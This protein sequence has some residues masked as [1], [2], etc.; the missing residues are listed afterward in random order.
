[1]KVTWQVGTLA[2]LEKVLE[3]DCSTDRFSSSDLFIDCP[4][5]LMFSYKFEHLRWAVWLGR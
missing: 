3:M 2:F 1:V 5:W 4:H